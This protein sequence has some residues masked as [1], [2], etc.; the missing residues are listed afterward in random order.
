MCNFNNDKAR[1]LSLITAFK[2]VIVKRH[3]ANVI[4]CGV[5]S[6]R[7]MMYIFKE[8]TILFHVNKLKSSDTKK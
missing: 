8:L 7:R 1:K 6:L 4:F 3:E 5:K 2:F